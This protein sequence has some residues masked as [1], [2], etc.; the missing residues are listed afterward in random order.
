MKYAA[1]D[2]HKTHS[3][4]CILDKA[5]GVLEDFRI[6]SIRS[7]GGKER[8][9]HITRRGSKFL[10]WILVEA[11]QKAVFTR[12]PLNPFY[13]SIAKR[14]GSGTAKVGAARKLLETIYQMLRTGRRFDP[15][16]WGQPAAG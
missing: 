12:S 8:H 6:A 13:W 2:A 3:Q 10:R 7:S 15:G 9:G 1:I 14:Q 5:T 16:V 4:A 11:A